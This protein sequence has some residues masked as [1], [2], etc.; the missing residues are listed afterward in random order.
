VSA[1]TAS[2]PTIVMTCEHGGRRVPRR[3]R[4][5]FAGHEA[6]LESHRAW[7]RGALAV[8]RALS[9][10]L[11]VELHHATTTRLLVDLNRSRH[12][13]GLFSEITRTLPRRERDRLLAELYAPFRDRVAT[14]VAQAAARGP[15]L[16]LSVH[17][18]TPVLDGRAR[19]VD[20]GLLYD[21][22]RQAELTLCGPWAEALQ[23]QLPS[24]RVRRNAPYRGATDGHVTAFRR[25]YDDATYRGVEIEVSQRLIPKEAATIAQALALTLQRTLRPSGQSPPENS[26]RSIL[27]S[28]R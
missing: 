7:D 12:H 2:A 18:F 9:A 14:V 3:Y 1:P 13:R 25:Q 26:G 28:R 15:V 11:E 22:G 21:P 24:L 6:L 16:H 23:R 10:R 27:A 19:R 4:A 17:S 8:A 20:V 5:L